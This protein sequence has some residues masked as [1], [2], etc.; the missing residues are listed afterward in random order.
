MSADHSQTDVIARHLSRLQQGD[1]NAIN[2]LLSHASQRLEHLTRK[3]LAGFAQVHSYEQTGDVM[4]NALIRLTKA[5]NETEVEDTR[6]FFRLAALQIRRELIDLSRRYNGRGDVSLDGANSSDDTDAAPG[7][8]PEANTYDPRQVAEW[9]D[10]HEEIAALPEKEREVV[11]L[12][13]YNGLSQAEAAIVMDVDVRSVKRYWQ[14]ARLSL[15]ESLK[16]SA[17]SP[18]NLFMP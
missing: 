7:I 3:M 18:V 2:D 12:L 11:D 10:F 15:H 16:G 8:V 1:A 17:T 5:L 13:L 14:R 4:Q 9:T 6:H